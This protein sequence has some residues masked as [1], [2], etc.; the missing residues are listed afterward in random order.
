MKDTQFQKLSIKYS[1]PAEMHMQLI[2]IM[3]D[4]DKVPKAILLTGSLDV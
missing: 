3:D 2:Y 4:A 1:R